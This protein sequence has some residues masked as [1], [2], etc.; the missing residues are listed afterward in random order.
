M[1]YKESV[2]QKI[3]EIL[4]QGASAPYKKFVADNHKTWIEHCVSHAKIQGI[5]A[6]FGVYRGKTLQQISKFTSNIV[7]GFDSFE[8]LHEDWDVNNP[9]NVYSLGGIVPLGALN[10]EDAYSDLGMYNSRPTENIIPWSSNVRLIKGFFEDSLPPFLETNNE[11]ASFL[12]IDSDLYSSAKTVLS[13]M[14]DRIIPGTILVFD[15][16]PGYPEFTDRNHEVKAFAEFLLETNKNYKAL[17]IQPHS[18]YSQF[19]YEICQ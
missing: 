11:A 7:Y 19:C 10:L 15:D 2:N 13:L 9:K 14:K 6:E 5:W 17:A 12:H 3:E 1:S 16:F 8:G 18:S 4:N